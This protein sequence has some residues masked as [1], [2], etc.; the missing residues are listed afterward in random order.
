[1]FN[2]AATVARA[3]E[4]AL[5]QTLGDLEIVC[6]DDGSSDGSAALARSYGDRLRVIAQDNR[7]PSA[8]RNAGAR[9][10]SG[11]FV[12]FLDADDILRPAMLARCTAELRANPESVLAYSNAEIID[13]AGRVLRASMVGAGRAHPPAMA[14]LLA[15]IWPIVPSTAVMRRAVFDACGGFNESLRSC[16]DIYFWLL[17]REHGPFIYL[18]EVLVQ[19]TEYQ[20]FPKVLERDAGAGAFA[21]LVRGRYGARGAGLLRDFNRMKARL[22]EQCGAEAI[23]A[24][25]AR[26]AR[27]C[28]A[29]AIAYQPAHVSNY[30]RMLKTFAAPAADSRK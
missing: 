15:H 10:A 2:S 12:A 4:S 5:A 20:L 1:M 6:V 24:G 23:R 25:R 30:V 17:A 8:A 3:I 19:K 29:R 27:R 13:D 11:E 28:F 26:D 7:G 18:A 14:D 9:A 16:E 21:G 22:L